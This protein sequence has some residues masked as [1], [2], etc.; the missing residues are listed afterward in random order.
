MALVKLA[1]GQQRSGKQGGIVWSHNRTGPYIRERAV[2]VNPNTDRQVDV[3][4]AVRSLAIGWTTVLTQNQRDGW[5]VYAA[6]V[7]WSDALGRSIFLTGLNHYIRSNTQMVALG[8]ARTNDAPAIQ[9]IGIAELA[10]GCAGSE[11]TQILTFTFDDTEVWASE[12][13][14]FQH[15]FMGIPQNASRKFFG[16]PWRYVVSVAGVTPAVSPLPAT[17]PWPFQEGQRIWVRSR[18]MRADGR[19][20]EFAQLNFLAAA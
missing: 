9:D 3:R 6:N 11:A 13:G 18:I 8:F 4:N 7:A 5:D 1:E 17:A 2:P 12:A 10:L 14:A 15:F 20:S 19:L 16:G